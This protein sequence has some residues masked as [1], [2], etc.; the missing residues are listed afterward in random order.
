M[1]HSSGG[2]KPPDSDSEVIVL[3]PATKLLVRLQYLLPLSLLSRLVYH[4]TRWRW[5]PWKNLL[6]R[7]FVRHY[8][9]DLSIAERQSASEYIHF[10]DFF[11]RALHSQARP[12]AA[13]AQA[14]VSPVDG[15]ISALG[16]V[17][18]GQLLQVKGS[19]Y[20]ASDLLTDAA[21]AAS[22]EQGAFMTLYLSPRDYHRIHMPC[23]GK[24]QR[25]I[26]VPGRR[27]AVN[28]ASVGGVPRLFARNERLIN[29]FE[30]ALGP[31][32]LIMVGALCVGSMHTVWAGT[33]PPTRRGNERDYNY[34]HLDIR[35]RHGEEM[36]RF[37]MGSTVILLFPRGNAR[38][39]T[40]LRAGQTVRMGQQIGSRIASERS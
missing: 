17:S 16:N 27:F 22:F 1:D 26:H 7:W 12:V 2:K 24:L 39:Q 25:M 4:I 21:I 14:I 23:A 29:L 5:P 8:K 33:L 34:K 28:Q 10:N 38:W 36:G 32:S 6:I 40:G 11:T 9:V 19:Y 30:T 20:T 18:K 35:L 13:A 31:V 37:N 15:T 3:S